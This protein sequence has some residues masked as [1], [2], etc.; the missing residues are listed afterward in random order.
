MIKHTVWGVFL[1]LVLAAPA[2]GEDVTQSTARDA[3]TEGRWDDARDA[4]KT[5]AQGG[6]RW[7]IEGYLRLLETLGD[8]D[9]LDREAKHAL[10]KHPEW[11][12]PLV[13]RA[14]VLESR[15][16][17][18]EGAALLAPISETSLAAA[19]ERSHLLDVTGD[20]EGARAQMQTASDLYRKMA[21][22]PAM[23]RYYGAIARAYLG[24]F[25]GASM[26]LQNTVADSTGFLEA[27]LALAS[28]F[29]EKYQASLAGDELT[30][31]HRLF[32]QHPDVHLVWA[33]LAYQGTKLFQAEV[34]AK[35]V[36]QIRPEDPEARVI[37]GRLAL[38]SD[39]PRDA[40]EMAEKVLATN[41]AHRDAR[42]LL[43]AAHYIAD[44]REDFEQ[45]VTRL[46]AQDPDYY[47]VYL[48]LARILEL[49]RR[50]DEAIALYDRVLE[51]DPEH[52]EALI[53]KGLLLMREGDET[54][55]RTFLE[56]G[57]AGDPFNIRA[58]NQ[59]ELL[60]EMETYTRYTSDHFEIHLKAEEDSMLVPMLL[61]D[62][63]A[64]YDDLTAL[65][66][67]KPEK[68]T[69]VEV[70]PSHDWFSARVTGF[71]QVPGIPAVC[72]GDIIATD[73]PRTL[74]GTSNWRDI[75][76]H[77]YGHVLALGMT[78]KR[79]PF[80]F[81]EGL[82]VFLE[83]F[84][85]GERWDTNL[86]AAW[87]DNGLVPLDS[88]TIA[89]TR[90][91]SHGQRMLAYHE[92]GLIV[93][94]LVEQHGWKIIPELLR[95]FG[96]GKSFDQALRDVLQTD[97]KRFGEHVQELVEAHAAALPVWPAPSR[98]RLD[99]LD[100]RFEE[101]DDDPAFLEL[102][103]LTRTQFHQADG[104]AE[105]AKKLLEVDPE[106]PRAYTGLGLTAMAQKQTQTA[107]ENLEAAA[108]G[109]SKDVPVYL[110]LAAL[111]LDAADTTRA[112]ANY[113]H[114]LTIYP[115]SL[116]ALGARA[117]LLAAMGRKDEARDAYRELL[118]SDA[119]SAGAALDLARMDLAAEDPKGALEAL[120]YA[121]GVLAVHPDVEA[122]MGR[123][124]LEEDREAEAYALFL[125]ARKLDLRNVEAM[126][127]MSRYYLKTGDVE[128]ATY[129][130]QLALKYDPEHPGAREALHL[131]TSD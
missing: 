42:A 81:T 26:L 49:E 111:Y 18:E 24:N 12:F 93:E 121:R 80:W 115:L 124:Y 74:A 97:P 59:L 29:R 131:A 104:V 68:P 30:E 48:D 5:L 6:E 107:L 118:A 58:Y 56:K 10:E 54:A 122:L 110:G 15:G 22:P 47:P 14:R 90:P 3:E 126:V 11:D 94:D 50:N 60:D 52:P 21:G 41:P 127:G 84:P 35:R 64:V 102:L 105:V 101:G 67:W 91:E 78:K 109:G 4:W 114:A 69:T 79:V 31:A 86:K 19:V 25:E 98:E 28:L 103:V 116:K 44:E 65:H 108:A 20:Q 130:A 63:E 33:D 57:F 55:A 2:R 125:K 95:T 32:P 61:Q 45:E 112:L 36:L 8:F 96:E 87:I 66:G 113:E 62:L 71:P 77:E 99:R 120:D 13:L 51:H 89:F 73:S 17:P 83:E 37:L 38:I 46:L 16:K 129:F 72:F 7:G 70:F 128:E 43:A 106:N 117:E 82:S 76:R 1:V 119:T 39:R 88:L 34:E 23:D 123:A 92:A 100:S 40:E 85:R 53:D 9:T 27:R 75:L